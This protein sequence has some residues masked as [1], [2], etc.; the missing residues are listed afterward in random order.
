MS[1]SADSAVSIPLGLVQDLA[2][3]HKDVARFGY[4]NNR[5]AVADLHHGWARKLAE[6]DDREWPEVGDD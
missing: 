5:T 2:D 6:Y 4:E 3:H 1:E